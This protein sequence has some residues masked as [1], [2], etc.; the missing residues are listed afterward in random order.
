MSLTTIAFFL[1]TRSWIFI[2]V[3]KEFELLVRG[4]DQNRFDKSVI[5]VSRVDDMYELPAGC[6]TFLTDYSGAAFIAAR[7]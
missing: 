2:Y 5:N 1:L 6:G 3:K 7:N 4:P